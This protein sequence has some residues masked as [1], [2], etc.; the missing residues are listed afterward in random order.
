MTSGPGGRVYVVSTPIGNLEDLSPR[1]ARVLAEVDAV[2]AE[3]TRRTRVLLDHVG[4]RTRLVSSHRHNEARRIERVLEWLAEGRNVAIVTDAGTPAVS[5]PG[6]RIVSAAAERGYPIVPIPG[7]SAV[8]AALAASGF[9][10]DRFRFEGFPPRSG[11]ARAAALERVATAQETTILFEAPTRLAILLRDLAGVCAESRR[12]AVGREITKVHEEFVRGTLPEAAAYYEETPPRGEVVVV[13]EG[14]P[15]T[16]VSADLSEHMARTLTDALLDHGVPPSG[17][18][19]EVARRTGL[20]RNQAYALAQERSS[21]P[22]E[23]AGET[24]EPGGSEG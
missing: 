9:G 23:S 17:V 20:S 7:A 13:V 10:G 21:T 4:A 22:L 16:E 15:P 1:A 6:A 3:D 5:D 18:A 14:G 24:G 12:V 19:R 2:L 8:L 11:A